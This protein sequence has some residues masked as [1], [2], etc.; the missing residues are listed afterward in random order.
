MPGHHAAAPLH[1]HQRVQPGHRGNRQP[2]PGIP[3]ETVRLRILKTALF[4]LSRGNPCKSR[5]FLFFV[6]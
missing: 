6:E 2:D 1:D 3:A 5:N 4:A